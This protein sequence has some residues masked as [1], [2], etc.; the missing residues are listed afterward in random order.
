M[1]LNVIYCYD[2][3]TAHQKNKIIYKCILEKY[4]QKLQLLTIKS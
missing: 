3:S 2:I 4:T 1:K